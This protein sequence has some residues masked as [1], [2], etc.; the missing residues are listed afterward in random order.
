VREVEL[1]AYRKMRKGEIRKALEPYLDDIRY[2]MGLKH[3]DACCS[4][5]E[6][7]AFKMI[8]RGL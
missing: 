4:S 5:T 6:K 7:A 2:S 3:G 1:S 8:E